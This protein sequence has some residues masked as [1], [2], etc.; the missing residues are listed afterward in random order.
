MLLRLG[1]TH[2]LSRSPGLHPVGILPRNTL[3]P[4]P[5]VEACPPKCRHRFQSSGCKP[6]SLR[7]QSTRLMRRDGAAW[8]CAGWSP[9]TEHIGDATGRQPSTEG[10]DGAPLQYE[11]Q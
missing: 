3:E 1:T 11:P 6:W 4:Q 7:S 10:R 9:T 8:D 2:D 5:L